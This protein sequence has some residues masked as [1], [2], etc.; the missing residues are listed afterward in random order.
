MS[1]KKVNV[2]G[3]G[4]GVGSFETGIVRTVFDL[5]PKLDIKVIG[6]VKRMRYLLISIVRI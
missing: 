6:R 3:I 4:V 2:S 5:V 1:G